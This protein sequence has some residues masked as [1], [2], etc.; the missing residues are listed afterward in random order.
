[1]Q[2]INEQVATVRTGEYDI[3]VWTDN[4]FPMDTSWVIHLTFYPL[5]WPGDPGYPQGERHGLPLVD[6]STFYGLNVPLYTRGKRASDAVAYLKELVNNSC[7][8]GDEFSLK[9]MDWWSNEIVLTNPPALIQEFI[10]A[11][12]RRGKI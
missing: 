1:M 7:E 8:D 6:T 3:N 11:L 5:M 9:S 12:P 2:F 10:N 4:E